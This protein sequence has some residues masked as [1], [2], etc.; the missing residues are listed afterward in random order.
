MQFVDIAVASGYAVLCISLIVLM[1][2]V[3]PREVSV[4]AHAQST[5]DSAVASYL[6]HVGLPFLATSSDGAVCASAAA[7]SNA[8][9]G[10]DVVLQ[11]QPCSGVVVPSSPIAYSSLTLDLPSRY[12]VIEAW[13]ARP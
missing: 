8:T 5:L 12:V 9:L 7:A 6:E 4:E 3:A 10:L 1:N 11:G 13:L 2:P